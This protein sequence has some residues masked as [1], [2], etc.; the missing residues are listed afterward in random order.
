MFL[1]EKL[2]LMIVTTLIA[3]RTLIEKTTLIPKTG[4]FKDKNYAQTVGY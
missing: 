1:T 4:N 2:K 3:G